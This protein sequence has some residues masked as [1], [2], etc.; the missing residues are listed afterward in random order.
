MALTPQWFGSD[1]DGQPF[2]ARIV[3]SFRHA[4][5][6][7]ALFE[8]APGSALE[9]AGVAPI[10]L[11]QGSIGQDWV[12]REAT[13]AGL[14]KTEAGRFGERRFVV[15][16][17]VSVS[18]ER[19]V[20]DGEGTRGACQGDSGGPL[21]ANTPAELVGILSS[22]SNSC[23]ELDRY[24]RVDQLGAW[25][26]ATT[27]GAKRDPCGDFDWEGQCTP[28]GGGP[29]W[30]DDGLLVTEECE[31]EQT[32][33]G[34]DLSARGYRCVAPESDPCGGIGREPECLDEAAIVRCVRGELVRK[35]CDCGRRCV[36]EDRAVCR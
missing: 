17:I 34:Y 32:A 7:L 36:I 35:D 9:G 31:K 16:T 22:G 25:I 26:R 30:C 3:R 18:T 27:E 29:V 8:L 2:A 19:L 15:E 4:E 11:F 21:L 23:V 6:D 13:L 33:C 12:G 28:G 5:R 10:P 20:V 14:G 1:V 24:E